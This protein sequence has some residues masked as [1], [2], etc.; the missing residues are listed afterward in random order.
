MALAITDLAL[1]GKKAEA[2]VKMNEGVP[3]VAGSALRRFCRVRDLWHRRPGA[4]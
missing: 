4:Q 2:I 3:P 1:N